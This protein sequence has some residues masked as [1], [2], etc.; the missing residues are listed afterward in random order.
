MR[1]FGLLA[2]LGAAF[3]L[4]ACG[5]G[6]PVRAPCPAGQICF[7]AGLGPDPVSIDPNLAS[8]GVWESRLLTDLF[9]G[10]TTDDAAGEVIPGAATSWETSADGLTWTFHL[11]P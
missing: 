4:T 8:G 10:L 5:D 11:R 2:A 6:K 7:E 1:A 9:M 3:L